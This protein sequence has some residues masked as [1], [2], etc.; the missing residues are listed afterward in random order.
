MHKMAITSGS[1]VLLASFCTTTMADHKPKHRSDHRD[2]GHREHDHGHRDHGRHDHGHRGNA[3]AITIG[4]VLSLI[5]DRHDSHSHRRHDRH[6]ERL[7]DLHGHGVRGVGRHGHDRHEDHHSHGPIDVGGGFGSRHYGQGGI[8]FQLTLG[9]SN[10]RLSVSSRPAAPM[11]APAPLP[12]TLPVPSGGPMIGDYCV[13]CEVAGSA[14]LCGHVRVKDPRNI[15]PHAVRR[16]IAVRDPH[17]CDHLCDCCPRQCV[18]VEVCMPPCECHDVKV[19]RDGRRIEYD[20][21]DYEIE[22]TSRNGLVTVDY[23]D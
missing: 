17:G 7:V 16:M 4:N 2:H 20:F 11:L 18:F 8:Q 23:D 14:P 19:S 22:V 3:A 10:P 5:A 6:R 9:G 13:G 1:L 12:G 21:G 15:A